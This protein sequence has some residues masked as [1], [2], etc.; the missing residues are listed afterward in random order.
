MASIEEFKQD[1]QSWIAETL[2][3]D[4]R[5]G[6]RKDLPKE[7]LGKWNDRCIRDDRS[8]RHHARRFSE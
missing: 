2:P 4:L 6:N 8:R 5:V 3:E 1:V 7:S